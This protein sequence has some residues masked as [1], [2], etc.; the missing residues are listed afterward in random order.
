MALQAVICHVRSLYLP[1][2]IAV[3]QSVL[4]ESPDRTAHVAEILT[5]S[6]GDGSSNQVRRAC[7]YK[8]HSLA[9]AE[10]F[11]D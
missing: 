1:D 2:V 6:N 11:D 5:N 4:A 7:Q 3:V 8:C 9:K 10:R